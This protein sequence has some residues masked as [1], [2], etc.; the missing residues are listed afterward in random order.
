MRG[1]RWILP[2]AVGLSLA[3]AMPARAA[4]PD[5]ATL[6]RL[7]GD[8]AQQA[9]AARGAPGIGALVRLPAGLSA[10]DVGLRQAAPG[11]ARLWGSPSTIVAFADAHP[12]LPI[13]VT[14]PLHLLLDT[15]TTYVTS[16]LANG[17]G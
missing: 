3:L 14:P 9:F 10:S 7:M 17:S 8:R 5:G 15:A 6:V 11:F 1:P 12:D 13:E 4:A 2:P 16:S